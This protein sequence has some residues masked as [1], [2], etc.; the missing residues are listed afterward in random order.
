[1][2]SPED[3]RKPQTNPF[4]KVKMAPKLGKPTDNNQNLS[5]SEGGLNISACQ[6]SGQSVYAFSRKCMET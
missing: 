6:I 2:Q 1:M 4:H 5:G 3:D